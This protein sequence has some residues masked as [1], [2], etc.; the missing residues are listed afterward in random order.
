VEDAALDPGDIIEG[1]KAQ[2]NPAGAA[3]VSVI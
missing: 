2:V 1:L 3:Q